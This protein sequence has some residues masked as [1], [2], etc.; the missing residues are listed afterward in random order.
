MPPSDGHDWISISHLP[1]EDP[2]DADPAGSEESRDF[3]AAREYGA[4]HVLVDAQDGLTRD[5][6]IRGKGRDNLVFAE[7]A[8]RWLAGSTGGPGCPTGTTIL[9]WEGTFVPARA[10]TSVK[11]IIASRGWSLAVASPDRLEDELR[12]AA[13]LWYV[14]DWE[15]PPG[16]ATTHVPLIERFVRAGGGLLAGGL[17]WS[18]VDQGAQILGLAPGVALPPYAANEL[19]EPFGFAFTTDAF[20][21]D[22]NQPI[23]LLTGR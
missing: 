12:C 10:M 3:I 2:S 9:L 22:P 23:P 19:G 11:A 6:E 18:Y 13:V 4:G 14:S 20:R 15:P 16:F 5:D 17:G 1:N 8:L 7:N 21:A